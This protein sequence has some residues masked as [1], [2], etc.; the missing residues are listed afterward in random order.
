[1]EHHRFQDGAHEPTPKLRP[2]SHRQLAQSATA[3]LSDGPGNLG[4]K[5]GR[6]GP[7]PLGIAEDVKSRE[8]KRL[9]EIAGRLEGMTVLSRKPHNHICGHG[10]PRHRSHKAFDQ[11]SELD[12]GVSTPHPPENALVAAL[13]RE[14]KVAAKSPRR[15]EQFDQ[16]RRDLVRIQRTQTDPRTLG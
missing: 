15:G 6:L 11:R 2:L 4:R 12:G 14:V 7:G 9:Q 8:R 1:V 13:E 10:N 16:L 5:A 3:F